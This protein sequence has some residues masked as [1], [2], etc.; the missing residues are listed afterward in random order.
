[1][2]AER[3][4]HKDVCNFVQLDVLRAKTSRITS[5]LNTNRHNHEI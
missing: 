4:I 3:V 2:D 1:M 5:V